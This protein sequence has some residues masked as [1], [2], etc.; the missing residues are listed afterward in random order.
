MNDLLSTARAVVFGSWAAAG[1]VFFANHLRIAR[2]RRS[3]PAA[4]ANRVSDRR[5]MLGFAIEFA[6]FLLLFTWPGRTPRTDAPSLWLAMFLGLASGVLIACA[7]WRLGRQWHVQ[8]VVT[9]S[10]RLVTSGPYAVLRHPIYAAIFGFLL[11]I[12]I[13]TADWVPT[14]AAS[15]VYIAGTE[16]RVRAEDRLLEGRFGGEFDDYR[17]RVKAY[18]PFVR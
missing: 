6:A 11:S 2:L 18:L 16:I 15:V 13:L 12:G 17:A 1:I 9:D 10:H 4:E 14:L 3:D 8:A 7:V 5:S